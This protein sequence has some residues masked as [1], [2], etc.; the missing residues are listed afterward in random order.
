M[1]SYNYETWVLWK[2]NIACNKK[3][4]HWEIE[5]CANTFRSHGI[6][7]NSYISQEISRIVNR[8][9]YLLFFALSDLSNP[10]RSFWRFRWTAKRTVLASRR[11]GVV[12]EKTRL[13]GRRRNFSSSHVT[14]MRPRIPSSRFDDERLDSVSVA[15]DNVKTLDHEDQLPRRNGNRRSILAAFSSTLEN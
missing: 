14:R 9:M 7:K 11:C 8:Y 5:E 13:S 12:A 10:L 3:T 2:R 4:L 15:L 1:L 6:S